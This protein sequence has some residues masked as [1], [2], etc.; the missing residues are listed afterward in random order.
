MTGTEY[1][2]RPYTSLPKTAFHVCRLNFQALMADKSL[3]FFRGV[4]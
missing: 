3:P 4:D 2:F 1:V